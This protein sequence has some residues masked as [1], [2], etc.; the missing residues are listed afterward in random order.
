MFYLNGLIYRFYGTQYNIILMIRN[1]YYLSISN[2]NI[3]NICI[4]SYAFEIASVFFLD[5]VGIKV[6]NFQY[7]ITFF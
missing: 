7:M 2:R 3:N 1:I 4:I 6:L 5:C